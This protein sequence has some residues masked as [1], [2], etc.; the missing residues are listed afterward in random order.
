MVLYGVTLVP[1]VEELWAA[2]PGLVTPFH[3]DDEVFDGSEMISSHL[4]KMLLE[5]GPDQGYFSEPP[6]S[7]FIEN[8][9][10]KRRRQSRSLMRR[11]YI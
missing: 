9:L 4:M 8:L 11:Y 10:I 7:L 3:A 1:L 2:E 6:K 5:R